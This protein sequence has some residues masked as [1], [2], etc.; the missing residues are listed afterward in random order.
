MSCIEMK[1]TP[2]TRLPGLIACLSQDA[3]KGR[4]PKPSK[5]QD[6]LFAAQERA[7]LQHGFAY[8]HIPARITA[9]Q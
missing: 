7:R 8:C 6:Q 5:S 2:T 3:G 9:G 1:K 4:D